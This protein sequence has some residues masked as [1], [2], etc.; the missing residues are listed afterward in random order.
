LHSI[1][2]DQLDHDAYQLER[3]NRLL[4]HVDAAHH[5]GLRQLD[6][7]VMRPSIDLGKLAADF[8]AKMPRGV[9]FLTRG[10]GTRETRDADFLS[11][12]MFQ[13]DYV[14]SVIAIGEE[15]AHRQR[16]AVLALVD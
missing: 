11:L 3:I 16:E 15:D 1:F 10:L 8:E 14:R 7:L 4:R 13:E 5:E 2:L 12:L 9:R 6:L